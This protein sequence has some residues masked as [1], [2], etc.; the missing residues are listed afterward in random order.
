[1]KA[2]I[3]NGSGKD[4]FKLQFIGGV[5]ESQLALRSWQV[6]SFIMREINIAD[7]LGCFSCWG[8]TPGAC[9]LD[10]AGFEI[11][12]KEIQSD[13]LVLLTPVTFG[14]YSYH[15]KKVIDRM[16]PVV[17]PFF[18][19]SLGYSRHKKRF[20]KYPSAIAIGLMDGEDPESEAIFRELI[21]RNAIN[22]HCPNFTTE[23]FFRGEKEEQIKERVE[24]LTQK[25]SQN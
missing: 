2:L 19:N 9:V 6:E 15:L 16:L 23:V 13:L 10:D 18:A 11:I 17:E 7:C 4:D 3:L 24:L 25:I 21:K 12:K 1:M 20:S 5:V 14:S 22:N 8:R